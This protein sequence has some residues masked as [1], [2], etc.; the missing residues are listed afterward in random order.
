LHPAC[1]YRLDDHGDVHLHALA[2]LP[3]L[4][5]NWDYDL[6]DVKLKG[7][8][9]WHVFEGHVRVRLR[10]SLVSPGAYNRVMG[11]LTDRRAP[12]RVLL[13]YFVGGQWEY[14][15]LR[16]SREAA[17][18]L[19]W[20][21]ELYGG[22]A[23]CNYRQ[24]KLMLSSRLPRHTNWKAALDF[25]RERREHIDLVTVGETF[26]PLFDGRWIL[27]GLGADHNFTVR[28]CGQ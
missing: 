16:K 10:P 17:R 4:S 25:W 1:G 3:H 12:E 7:D 19:R 28:A 5:C 2:P 9:D 22:G 26:N 27:Y 11:W 14:E 6:D 24:H 21:V 8:V 20:L 18:R 23:W 15:F 13:C